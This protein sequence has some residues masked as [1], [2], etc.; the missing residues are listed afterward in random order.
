MTVESHAR[1]ADGQT[2]GSAADA[3]S[4]DQEPDLIRVMS[5]QAQEGYVK[6]V[7]LD[8]PN[9]TRP[10][11]AVEWSRQNMVKPRVPTVYESDGKTVTGTFTVGKTQTTQK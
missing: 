10:Q 8:P 2:Y 5:D 3:G 11:D 4:R 1:N 6:K 9:F 7:D